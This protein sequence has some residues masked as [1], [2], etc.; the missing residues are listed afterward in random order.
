MTKKTDAPGAAKKAAAGTQARK[1]SKSMKP[2]SPKAKEKR[3]AAIKKRMV[4]SDDGETDFDDLPQP[5]PRKAGGGRT[6]GTK[7]KYVEL[8]SSD[9]GGDESMFVD[10]S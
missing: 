10:D 9:E 2:A 8:S 6:T 3:A 5:P 7:S 1:V 4:E